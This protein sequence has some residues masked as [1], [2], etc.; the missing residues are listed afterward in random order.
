MHLRLGSL[1]ALLV[2]GYATAVLAFDQLVATGAIP[3]DLVAS[4]PTGLLHGEL[5]TMLS[6]G[7][8]SADDAPLLHI[9]GL[10]IVLVAFAARHGGR[11]VLRCALAA[12]VGS[13]LLA[14]AG[15]LIVT[16]TALASD[17]AD[18][19]APDYGTSCVWFGCVAGLLAIE[20][21]AL[22]GW[23][24]ARGLVLAGGLVALLAT[25]P[26]SEDPLTTAEHLL[27]IA[28]GAGVGA[29]FAGGQRRRDRKDVRERPLTAMRQMISMP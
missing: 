14:Y 10:A 17:A 12:H 2:A 11:V 9:G 25:G 8:V 23:P 7:L 5:W 20:L 26:L 4:S 6:S 27:A 13:A 18:L 16:G 3:L 1:G 24:L 19:T 15:L 29:R 21:L 28:I 22:R